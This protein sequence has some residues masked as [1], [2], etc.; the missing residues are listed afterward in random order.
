MGPTPVL[1]GFRP[2]RK[3]LMY[4]APCVCD[5]PPEV[6][7]ESCLRMQ[8]STTWLPAMRASGWPELRGAMPS[9][10]LQV[11]AAFWRSRNRKP[12]ALKPDSWL[13]AEPTLSGSLR[14]PSPEALIGG[15]R[16]V[17]APPERSAQ[18]TAGHH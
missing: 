10:R 16:G 4:R 2:P 6:A 3:N 8:S 7:M 18:E 14:L 11:S 5:L 15:L 17:V 1:R 12:L 13:G 9:I